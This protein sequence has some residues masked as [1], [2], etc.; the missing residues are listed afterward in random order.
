[1]QAHAGYF[2][3]KNLKINKMMI[4]LGVLVNFDAETYAH[5][6]KGRV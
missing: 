5:L 3:W 6:Q 2:F 4:L 1:M